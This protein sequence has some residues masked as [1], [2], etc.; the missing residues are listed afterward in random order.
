M[1]A[2]RSLS[3]PATAQAIWRSS[4]GWRFPPCLALI[5]RVKQGIAP[6]ELN[7]SW[8]KQRGVQSSPLAQARIL[9]LVQKVLHVLKEAKKYLNVWKAE[10]R[11]KNTK[12]IQQLLTASNGIG[13][14]TG[15]AEQSSGGCN[16]ASVHPASTFPS[17]TLFI[18]FVSQN[19]RWCFLCPFYSPF[20]CYANFASVFLFL[21]SA[22]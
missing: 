4:A 14:A 3:V 22:Y 1:K 15:G 10:R 2:G 13:V 6:E 9:Y 7:N 17:L 8:I 11:P 18:P 20:K 21:Q 12:H 19:Q 16:C 5:S